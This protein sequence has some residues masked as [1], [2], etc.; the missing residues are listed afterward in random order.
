M[1]RAKCARIRRELQACALAA[2][3]EEEGGEAAAAALRQSYAGVR[4]NL[5]GSG[6]LLPGNYVW[7]SLR[8]HRLL[9]DNG[10]VSCMRQTAI[11]HAARSC[12]CGFLMER[13]MSHAITQKQV[14]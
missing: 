3:P 1:P 6:L 4:S 5:M 7:T 13:L 14:T 12:L 10:R 2:I 11:T 9:M 8:W